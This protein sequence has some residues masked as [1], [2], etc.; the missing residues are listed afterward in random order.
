MEEVDKLR[1]NLQEEEAG[2][3][4]ASLHPEDI[5]EQGYLLDLR[6]LLE[7]ICRE[8]AAAHD[9]DPSTCPTQSTAASFTLTIGSGEP[10][11]NQSGKP[12]VSILSVCR[13]VMTCQRAASMEL[14]ALFD[15]CG[16]RHRS[17]AWKVGSIHSEMY[18]ED[19][20][21]KN[22]FHL[23]ND[24]FSREGGSV[25]RNEVGISV[26]YHKRTFP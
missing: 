14:K 26:H 25:A 18:F 20:Q 15:L 6:K 3:R 12:I 13:H 8:T 9:C 23:S 21:M 10:R 17:L 11:M 7:L 24:L 5:Q 16:I 19:S 1:I 22:T 2:N 4:S